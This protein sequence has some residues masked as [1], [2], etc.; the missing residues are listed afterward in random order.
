M[1]TYTMF[2]PHE[3]LHNKIIVVLDAESGKDR[4]LAAVVQV[5]WRMFRVVTYLEKEP[6]AGTLTGNVRYVGY[7]RTQWS[8]FYCDLY[9]DAE[10][11]GIIDSDVQLSQRPN[12]ED[13]F[14]VANRPIIHIHAGDDGE[15]GSAA[16]FMVGAYFPGNSM[17]AFPY[18]IK[19]AHL[20][21]MR[22]HIV[23]TVGVDTFEQAWGVMQ[24]RFKYW[25]QFAVM[26]TYLWHHHFDEYA[27]R[28]QGLFDASQFPDKSSAQMTAMFAPAV[29]VSKHL[30]M[31]TDSALTALSYYQN[32]CGQSEFR[33]VDCNADE[34]TPHSKEL[35]L[36]APWTDFWPMDGGGGGFAP[37]G[38]HVNNNAATHDWKALAHKSFDVNWREYGGEAAAERYGRV[39][40]TVNPSEMSL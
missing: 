31:T 35:M 40:R 39:G 38:A 20:P 17:V 12:P 4:T 24:Q 7:S 25:G 21:L 22:A 13:L 2:W 5:A 23:K 32:I 9:T 18:M 28:F 27:F 34:F 26:A 6:P 10:Y 16:V 14:D 11:V 15:T 37:G 33:A 30:P 1:F 19:T 29:Y 8:N 3:E 36:L